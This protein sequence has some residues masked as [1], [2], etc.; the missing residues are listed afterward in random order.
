MKMSSDQST[1]NTR[2]NL[3][4]A[5]APFCLSKQVQK[6][7]QKPE[8]SLSVTAVPFF[9]CPNGLI[10]P[11]SG[12]DETGLVDSSDQCGERLITIRSVFSLSGGVC[13]P[14]R[15]SGALLPLAAVRHSFPLATG[16][17][18]LHQAQLVSV[19]Q[20]RSFLPSTQDTETVELGQ[21][22]LCLP[23]DVSEYFVTE[24]SNPQFMRSVE[25]IHEELALSIPLLEKDIARSVN[26]LKYIGGFFNEYLSKVM[27][28]V[29]T[30]AAKLTNVE[31]LAMYVKEFDEWRAKVLLVE[32]AVHEVE[33]QTETALSPEYSSMSELFTG[34]MN[35]MEQQLHSVTQAQERN[36]INVESEKEVSVGSVDKFENVEYNTHHKKA[37]E[38]AARSMSSPLPAT[39]PDIGGSDPP[40]VSIRLKPKCVRC[41]E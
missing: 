26:E 17:H 14:A 1:I 39:A 27:S 30:T 5:A 12:E 6:N 11:C 19:T 18:F 4:P 2:S 3:S 28:D 31:K 24:E 10:K 38:K 9:S 40:I 22:N 8:S 20:I 21:A 34:S 15:L 33:N 7:Q 35:Y 16:L 41:V 32:C 29:E 23:D 36:E 13:L 37:T 25:E